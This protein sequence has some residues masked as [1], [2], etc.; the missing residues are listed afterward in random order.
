[1]LRIRGSKN[2]GP[3]FIFIFVNN[4]KNCTK[5]ICNAIRDVGKKTDLQIP[6]GNGNIV[7]VGQAVCGISTSI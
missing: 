5:Y 3:K 7:E 1:M 4:T 6:K 2:I